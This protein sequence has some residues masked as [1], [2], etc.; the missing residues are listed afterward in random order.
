[1]HRRSRF[2]VGL[3]AA[4]VTFCSLWFTLG[5]SHFNCGH[6]R[7]CHRME[8]HC[9]MQESRDNDECGKTDEFKGKKVY[10]IREEIKTDSIKK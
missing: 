5:S 1:M 2:L 4:T 8:H 7:M 9:W 6:H 10:I 3:A